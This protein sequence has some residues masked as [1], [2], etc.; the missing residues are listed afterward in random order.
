MSGEQFF[1]GLALVAVL[2]TV[3]WLALEA[4]HAPTEV[5]STPLDDLMDGPTEPAVSDADL[6][7]RVLGEPCMDP[8]CAN[9]AAPFPGEDDADA[10]FASAMR[11]LNGEAADVV[12]DPLVERIV[13]IVQNAIVEAEAVE[14]EECEAE[15]LADP[16]HF[17]KAES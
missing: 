9:C 12:M 5:E 13:G 6:R 1:W 15:F 4:V 14:L 7:A 17:G 8:D 3:G 11:M 10:A 2:A 16:M